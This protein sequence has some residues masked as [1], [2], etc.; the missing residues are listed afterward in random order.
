MSFSDSDWTSDAAA[1]ATGRRDGAWIWTLAL[2]IVI[3]AA[4]ATLVFLMLDRL[5]QGNAPQ[6]LAVAPKPA[7]AVSPAPARAPATANDAVST[8]A[9]PSAPPVRPAA[10]PPPEPV[11]DVSS[12]ATTAPQP[13]ADERRRKERAWAAYYRRPASCEGNPTTDQL[14]ECANHF[15]RSKRE[16]EERWKAGTL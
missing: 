10:P 9:G 2:G 15:I 1:A 14:I 8:A 6:A 11:P 3:G 4:G 7:P 16:F 13:S 12:V 5:P